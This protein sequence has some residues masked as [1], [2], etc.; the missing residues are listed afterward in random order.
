MLSTL[1]RKHLSLLL[2]SLIRFP[3]LISLWKPM[4]WT[5]LSLQFYLLLMIIMK[6]IWLLFTLILLL[7]WSW[8]TTHI[9]RNYL[10]SLKLS[11]FCNTIWKVRPI[12][13]MLL[14]IIRTL[15][16]FLLPRY[17]SRDKCGSLSTFSSS[18]LPSGSTLVVSAPN[19]MLSL[20]NGTYILKRRI[21]A[22]L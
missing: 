13:S 22:I 19:Q 5:M 14:Q 6:F 15:S 11:R 4:L 12:L 18:I 3:M 16:I 9:T 2:F 1:S 7:W 10:L 20:N 8:I 21:L 17:W